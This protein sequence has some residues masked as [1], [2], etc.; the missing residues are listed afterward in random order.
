M[1]SFLSGSFTQV[2]AGYLLLVNLIA[3]I[4]YGVDKAK[5][6]KGA[7][8]I[9]ERVLILS[10]FLGGAAGA[11]AGMLLFRHKTKHLKFRILVPLALV[12]WIGILTYLF[13]CG[14]KK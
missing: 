10:A 5:A 9:P 3:L 2:L 6:K 4:L 14:L 13:I 12:L 7:W 1:Q 8:R 11:L